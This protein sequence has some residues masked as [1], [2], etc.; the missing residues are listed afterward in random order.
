VET[1]VVD[2]V[3]LAVAMTVKSDFQAT[4]CNPELSGF[5]VSANCIIESKSKE[6]V[7]LPWYNSHGVGSK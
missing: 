3:G 2:L 1:F 7:V 5:N 4:L 6:S